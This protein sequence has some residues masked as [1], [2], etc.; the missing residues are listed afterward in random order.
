MIFCPSRRRRPFWTTSPKSISA[1]CRRRLSDRSRAMPSGGGCA[2]SRPNERVLARGGSVRGGNV[3]KRVIV[4]VALAL[5]LTPSLP[6]AQD[7]LPALRARA[8]SQY[9]R[10]LTGLRLQLRRLPT[11]ASV[12]HIGAHPDDEDSALIA[13]LARGDGARVGY[14]SLTRGEGGQN[15]LGPEQGAALGLIRAEELAEAR[16]IDGGEQFFT[17]A[18]DF[19]FS[20]TLQETEAKWSALHGQDAVLR[21]IA[22]VIREFKPLVIVARWGGTP[23]D[24]H[25]HHQYCGYLTQI[26]FAKA[27]DPNWHPE[28]GPAWQAKKLYVSADV[29][30]PENSNPTLRIPTGVYD[31]LLGRTYFQVAMQ[32]RSQHK[33]QEMGALEP[34]DERF[35]GVKLVESLAPT[36][37]KTETSLFDGL[38]TSLRSLLPDP[39]PDDARRAM[40]DVQSLVG[41]LLAEPCSPDE[42]LATLTKAYERLAQCGLAL[43]GKPLDGPEGMVADASGECPFDPERDLPPSSALRLKK[44]QIAQAILLAAGFRATALADAETVTEGDAVT[45]SQSLRIGSASGRQSLLR[46]AGGPPRLRGALSGFLP[47]AGAR[48]EPLRVEDGHWESV[49]VVMPTKPVDLSR[50][51]PWMSALGT[52]TINARMQRDRAYIFA[53]PVEY[54]YADPARGE[55]SGEVEVVPA[56][57]A[58]LSESLWIASRA[59]ESRVKRVMATVT[60]HS[61]Q[62]RSGT[63]TLAAPAGWRVEPPT[64]TMTLP[65]K[66]KQRALFDVTIPGDAADGRYKLTATVVSDGKAYDRDVQAVGYPHIQTRR[67][68]PKAEA[69]VVI[70][71]VKAAPVTV[72]YVMGS[73]DF[74]PQAI[75]RLGLPVTL[76][77]EGA[78]AAGDLR[79][80]DV[81]VVGIRASQT[82]PDFAA[83]H[84][85]LLDY[86]R[87]GGTLIVQYQRPD[88]LQ[89]GLPPFP[90][91]GMTRTT[92]ETAPVTM[93]RPEHPAFN[94]PNRITAADWDGWVQER[95]LYDFETYD[96]RYTPLLASRDPGEPPRT[97]GLLVAELGQGRYVY[98]SYAWFRQLPAGVPG[99]Y[100]IFANLL[101]LP[102]APAGKPSQGYRQRPA[103]GRSPGSPS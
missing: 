99:A 87:E 70:L 82:R 90:A 94:F 84:A 43:D 48:I 28:L 73:G 92:D 65:P 60:N 102:K 34:D 12:L 1:S 16:A 83:E 96:A 44:A 64:T 31:P 7:R 2:R 13:R 89:R 62:A 101:S 68:F 32:G 41:R 4:A 75:E 29:A 6:K 39:A 91:S 42:T 33:S 19:G 8:R 5:F 69:E 23:R 79:K 18:F 30:P 56:I 80:F 51:R 77:D 40:D 36:N 45:I 95:S 24:G 47:Y 9:D 37:P 10:G 76:L 17:R 67:L 71:D 81:I 46:E 63:L 86:V 50:T 66:A 98:A 27:A 20:K 88:Y 55:V 85:R 59:P 52:L 93:L 97:G 3:L 15:R 100:R 78:L 103:S 26:A 49:R 21:D 57:S 53:I 58:R 11:T 72:G 14:L 54:R 74:V 61:R 25:G 22:R 35:S 38:D